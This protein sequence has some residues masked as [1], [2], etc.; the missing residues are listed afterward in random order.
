MIRRYCFLLVV[1]VLAVLIPY[2]QD[3]PRT[4]YTSLYREASRLYFSPNSSDSNDSLALD[5]YEQVI[6][7]AGVTDSVSILADACVKAGILKMSAGDNNGSLGY[8]HRPVQLSQSGVSIP[9]SSLFESYLYGGSIHYTLSAPDS[10]SWYYLRAESILER[11][12]GLAEAGRLYNKMGVLYFETGDYR[13]SSLYFEKALA[14]VDTSNTDLV[15]NFRNNIGNCY[16]KLGEYDKALHVFRDLLP[17]RI[18]TDLLNINI[19]S[20]LLDNGRPAEAFVYLDQI[21]TEIPEKF[22]NLTRY[23]LMVQQV[24]EADAANKKA[25]AI[26]AASPLKRAAV[27]GTALKLQGDI[28]LAK[29]MNRQG[30][31]SYQRAIVALAPGFRGDDVTTNPNDFREVPSFNILFDALRAKALA[32]ARSGQ[33]QSDTT[34][35]RC[36]L[37]AFYSGLALA[38]HI[39]RVYSTDDARLFLKEK[40]NPAC[41]DAVNTALRLFA[42]TKQERW[43][44]AA[45]TISETNKASVLQAAVRQPDESSVAGLPAALVWEEKRYKSLLARYSVQLARLADSSG[46][47]AVQQKLADAALKLSAI[48]RKLDEN[49]AYHQ[50]KF[51]ATAISFEK[52]RQKIKKEEAVLSY[53]YS[54][55]FL[56]CFYVSADTAEVQ[57]AP[58]PASFIENILALRKELSSLDASDRNT[59]NALSANLYNALLRPISK[60]LK[61][62][63]RLVIIP[64]NEIN[65]IPF[66]M[67][68]DE[69]GEPVLKKYAVS[70]Q[71]AAGFLL[72][73]ETRAEEAYSVLAVAPFVNGAANAV[74]PVLPS[75]QEELQ[76]LKGEQLIGEQASRSRF[77]ALSGKYPVIHLATHAVADDSDPAGS[78]IAFYGRKGTAD[79]AYRF[80]EREIYNLDMKAARLVILSACETGAG[81]LVNGEGVFSLSRAFSYAGCQSVITSLWKADDAAT[82]FI[83]QHLHQYLQQGYRKDE[84]LQQARL[85]YLN[86]SGTPARYKAPAYWAHLAVIGSVSPVVTKNYAVPLLIS[87]GVV[88]LLL[89]FVVLVVR[90]RKR[91]QKNGATS[92]LDAAP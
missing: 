83:M 20:V 63:K 70:Y 55:G 91:I 12:S 7:S 31:S 56:Y 26:V 58:I 74:L 73:D 49:P 69:S 86:D 46:K 24:T 57:S 52:I 67:L 29:G 27:E 4:H 59:T 42:L 50:L 65:Y 71:Y 23:Y 78:Y 37:D 13:K 72:S 62:K 53:Y 19:S 40:V 8:F 85:D 32:F 18:N 30:L 16:L 33:S 81:K 54:S 6:K 39:E 41:A 21:K 45:F 3:K 68:Q 88:L 10:A 2:G 1:T 25:L 34:A 48:Q 9:D 11:H 75:A 80:Y 76:G 90:R 51:S 87:L 5:R 43:E 61:D 92:V 44:E 47:N 28:F 84:A 77:I 66:E 89:V 22:N 64:Y 38:R 17:Y 15:V 14:L 82:A 79:T 60:R 36:S 35:L